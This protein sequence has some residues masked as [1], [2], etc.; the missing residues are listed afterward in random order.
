M[1][2]NNDADKPLLFL[3]VDGVISLYGYSTVVGA[4]GPS[5]WIDDARHCVREGCGLRLQR[6]AESFD[7][8][9]ATGWEHRANEHLVEALGLPFGDLPTLVFGDRAVFGS[10]DWKVEAID[11]YAQGRPSVWIDDNIDDTCRRWAA[12]REEPTLLVQTWSGTGLTDDH[13][14]QL[15]YWI[16]DVGIARTSIRTELPLKF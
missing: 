12:G 16:E 6:L 5:V 10:A 13:V 1:L 8:V 7:L 11:A 4:P 15:E 2:L 3:D 14:R 9:W